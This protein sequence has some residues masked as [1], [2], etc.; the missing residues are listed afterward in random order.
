MPYRNTYDGG[1]VKTL[2]IMILMVAIGALTT[3]AYATDVAIKGSVTQTVEGSDNYFLSTN[4]SGPTG[5]TNTAGLL[6]FYTGTPDTQY[7]L[8]TYYSYYKYFGPGA[9]DAGSI[10][11]GTPA[12]AIFRMNHVTELDRF[13]LAAS[14]S[15]TD[16]AVTQLAQ[17]GLSNARGSINTY[18]VNAGWT[19]DLGRIDTLSWTADWN[20]V[21]FT[22]PTQTPYT[23]ITSAIT[24]NHI[25]GPTTTFS[26]SVV[27]DWFSQDNAA[28]SQR[29]LWRF[30]S[31]VQSQLTPRLTFNGQIG[32]VFANAYQNGNV[33]ASSPIFIPGV[34]PFQPLVGAGHGWVGNV[35]LTYRLLKD[36]TASF[37]A[38]QAITP[39]F[40]GQLQQTSSLTMNLNHQINS[41]SSL[42]FFASYV[43]STSPNQIG[44]IQFS[45]ANATTS[46]F[47]SAGVNYNYQ[48]TRDL[49]ANVSYTFRDS[50]TVAK[51][52]TVLVGLSKSFN[53]TGNPTPINA[54]EQE[55]AKLRAQ[56]P[57]GYVFPGFQ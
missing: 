41:L 16:A 51:S 31:G 14:W 54:A 49:T 53:V 17:T 5:K 38:A 12:N 22:D 13:N 45:Q 55:R 32:L 24:W 6:N 26:N 23:D 39:V 35:G 18:D 29:L 10:Q 11:W 56:Q 33:Q 21:S 4:P 25:F 37:S 30:L 44:P 8:D 15:R 46:D 19:R 36:T 52:S 7:F 50:I 48:L 2:V 43:E 42:S 57:T 3:G 34:T 20:T 1:V 9:V 40:T 28:N 27:F 47:F